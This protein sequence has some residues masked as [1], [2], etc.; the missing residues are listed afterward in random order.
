VGYPL[1][2]GEWVNLSVNNLV[3]VQLWIEKDTDKVAAIYTE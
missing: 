2:T 3:G 1:F